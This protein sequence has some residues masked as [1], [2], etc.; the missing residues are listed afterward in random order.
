M[1]LPTEGVEQFNYQKSSLYANVLRLR[2]R[3][4]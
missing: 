4:S 2:M 3:L 1:R